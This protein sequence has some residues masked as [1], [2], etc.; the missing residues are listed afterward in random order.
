MRIFSAIMEII[1]GGPQGSAGPPGPQGPI[2]ETGLRGTKWYIGHGMPTGL[3]DVQDGDMYLDLDTGD[4]YEL[5][6]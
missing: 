1:S 3:V 2:G 4:V 6:A 5:T